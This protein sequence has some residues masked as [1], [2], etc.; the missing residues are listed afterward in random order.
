M[1]ISNIPAKCWMDFTDCVYY[2]TELTECNRKVTLLM[3]YMVRAGAVHCS[4]TA[5]TNLRLLIK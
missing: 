2:W 4:V 3:E 1:S 5:N